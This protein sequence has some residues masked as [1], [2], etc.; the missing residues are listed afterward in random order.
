MEENNRTYV[1]ENKETGVRIEC[2]YKYILH[3]IARG[4]EVIEITDE[5]FSQ[6]LEKLSSDGDITSTY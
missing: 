4:F 1:M 6:E 3:W 5:S 2:T